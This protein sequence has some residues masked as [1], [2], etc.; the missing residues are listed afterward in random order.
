TDSDSIF[1]LDGV[2]RTFEKV[3]RIYRL[4]DTEKRGAS[5]DIALNISPGPHKDTQEL[6]T[7]EFRWF[8][9]YLKHDDSPI[10]TRAPK[11]FQPEQLRVFDKLPTD[12][13]NTRIHEIFVAEAQAAHV[14]VG[15]AEW[16]SMRHAWH[17]AIEWKAFG[18]WATR[19]PRH[20]QDVDPFANP[21][22]QRGITG[23]NRDGIK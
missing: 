20:L 18:A 4:F 9:H 23:V 16:N 15:S 6:N 21:S 8:N 19:E 22:D 10:D 11:Y 12:Q 1:P 17:A 14:P 7:H 13:I 3:R 5:A 2:I